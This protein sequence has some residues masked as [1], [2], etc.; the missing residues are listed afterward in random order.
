L[1]FAHHCRSVARS[2]C[3]SVGRYR[4]R[5]RRRA[6]FPLISPDAT[7][8]PVP[9]STARLGHA[10]RVGDDGRRPSRDPRAAPTIIATPPPPPPPGALFVLRSL[11]WPPRRS[12]DVFSRQCCAARAANLGQFAPPLRHPSP[13]PD[14]RPNRTINTNRHLTLI[15][16]TITVNFKPNCNPNTKSSP[17]P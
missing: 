10:A 13:L 7:W 17:Q 5:R 3:R 9:A 4:S 15:T 14:P 2:V 12:T 6:R 16:L 1:T 11:R 8:L